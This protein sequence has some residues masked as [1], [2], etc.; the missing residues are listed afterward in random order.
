VHAGHGRNLQLRLHGGAQRAARDAVT[1]CQEGGAGD[2]KVRLLRRHQSDQLGN[3]AIRV[4]GGVIVAADDRRDDGARVAER[5]L[6]G[7]SRA[8]SAVDHLGSGAGLLLA[9]ELTEELI[10]ERDHAQRHHRTS[11]ITRV[12]PTCSI[13]PQSPP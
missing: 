12:S 3:R 7:P 1:A 13:A 2:E 11:A 10:D 4:L 8:D 9:A 5:L 6:D